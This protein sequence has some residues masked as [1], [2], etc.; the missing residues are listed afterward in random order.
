MNFVLQI[1]LKIVVLQI[2]L[3]IVTYLFITVC[4]FTGGTKVGVLCFRVQFPILQ[5]PHVQFAGDPFS[6]IFSKLLN[7]RSSG[8]F[9][10]ELRYGL[11]FKVIFC[12]ISKI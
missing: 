10:G 3:Q 4:L 7:Y 5:M 9:T 1:V 12:V 11:A 8:Q 2:V 6:N